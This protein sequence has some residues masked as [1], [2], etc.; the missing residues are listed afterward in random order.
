MHATTLACNNIGVELEY[1]PKGCTSVAQPV[2]VGFNSLL[3]SHVKTK[4]MRWQIVEYRQHYTNNPNQ[5]HLKLPLPSTRNIVDWV[6]SVNEEIPEATIRKTFLSIRFV[7]PVIQNLPVDN[8][9]ENLPVD[10]DDQSSEEEIIVRR[11]E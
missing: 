2:N 9:D 11:I 3:K 1:V 6:F 10:N 4:Y 5:Q 8:D 7:M